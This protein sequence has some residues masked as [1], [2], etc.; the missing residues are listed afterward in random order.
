[1]PF[2]RAGFFPGPAEWPRGTA[3][4]LLPHACEKIV[5]FL[6]LGF[7]ASPARPGGVVR[8]P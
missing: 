2:V 6:P 5:L 7:A 1:M 4:S 8:R 3:V